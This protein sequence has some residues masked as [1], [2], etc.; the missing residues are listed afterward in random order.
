[1]GTA[2]IE[3]LI[4]ATKDIPDQGPND[5]FVIPE[6]LESPVVCPAGPEL[7]PLLNKHFESRDYAVLR[8]IPA[9]DS[10]NNRRMKPSGNGG[11]ASI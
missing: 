6:S 8:W 5:I 10:A 3:E 2:E 9:A 7:R 1:V 11:R 4:E